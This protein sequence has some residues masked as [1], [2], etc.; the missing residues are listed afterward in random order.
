MP[1]FLLDGQAVFF[2][3]APKCAGTAVRYYLEERFG[4]PAFDDQLFREHLKRPTWTRSTPQH[5]LT[6]DMRLLFPPGFFDHVFGMVRHPVARIVSAYRWSVLHRFTPRSVSL[7]QWYD[8]GQRLMRH[9]FRA[10]DNHLAR[11]VDVIPEEATVFRV[12]DG[13]DQLVGYL[14]EISGSVSDVRSIRRRNGTPPTED[15]PRTT[16]APRL[17]Q[18]IQ[19]DYAADFERFGY[20]PGDTEEYSVPAAERSNA[21]EI[22]KA[23]KRSAVIEA[24]ILG[25]RTGQR[26]RRY[27]HWHLIAP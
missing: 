6:S 3:H 12:E 17:F 26:L 10:Y 7:E 20:E 4:H 23:A 24:L 11:L 15:V 5:L 18:R 22:V 19:E 14:D 9:G 13:L 8:Q 21:G 2:A 1:F 25:Q 16:L 27:T